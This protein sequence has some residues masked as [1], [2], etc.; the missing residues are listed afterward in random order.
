MGKKKKNQENNAP[1]L[2]SSAADNGNMGKY[3]VK[4]SSKKI[5]KR[6]AL[7][8]I[9]TIILII[10]LLLLFGLFACSTYITSGNFT[11][12]TNADA[13]NAGIALSETSDFAN[14]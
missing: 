7:I 1:Q 11:V 14:P 9:L 13:Y 12:T 10:L 8:R 5:N 6:E 4:T 3:S 2:D